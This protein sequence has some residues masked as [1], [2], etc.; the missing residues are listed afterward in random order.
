MKSFPLCDCSS[1][2]HLRLVKSS[3][4]SSNSLRGR[5]TRS[6]Q[7]RNFPCFL[8][9]APL[10]ALIP[11]CS[12]HARLAHSG[13]CVRFSVTLFSYCCVLFPVMHWAS[14]VEVSGAVQPTPASCGR[15]LLGREMVCAFLSRMDVM[16]RSLLILAPHWRNVFLFEVRT[17]AAH[18]LPLAG[19]PDSTLTIYTSLIS[20]KRKDSAANSYFFIGLLFLWRGVVVGVLCSLSVTVDCMRQLNE[21]ILSLV[22]YS[23]RLKTG[24]L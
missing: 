6:A 8:A 5:W 9:W 23:W 1:C 22:Y 15:R 7:R 13:L 14:G 4:Y 12:R 21:Y 20:F 11:S 18:L 19:N 3:A 2:V 16:W 17:V 24:G 10:G